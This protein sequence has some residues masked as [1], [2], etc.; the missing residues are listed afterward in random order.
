[1]H[2]F[3]KPTGLARA[4]TLALLSSTVAALPCTAMA[5]EWTVAEVQP[6]VQTPALTDQDADADADDPAIYVDAADTNKSFVVTAVKNGGIRVYDFGGQ[7]LQ[8]ILPVED[9]RINNVDIV[10]DFKMVDGSV[11]DLAIGADRG[12][13]VIRIYRI[14]ASGG[15]PLTEITAA[16]AARAFPRR[17]TSDGS[18]EEENPAEDQA[19]VY[20][21]TA[22]HDKAAEKVSVV[23]TQRHQPVVGIFSLEA[24]EGGTVA[25]VFDH[26]FQV[27]TSHSGQDLWQESEED[28]LADF[29]PQFE[30]VVVDRTTGT[31]YAGQEDVGIWSVPVSGGEPE[32]AYETR[33]SSSSSFFNPDSV[34]TRDVEGLSIYYAAS[35]TRYLLAS[36][37]GGAHGEPPVVSDAPYDDSFVVFDLGADELEPLGSFRVSAAENIDAVQESDGDD[38][39]SVALPGFPNGVFITQDGYAGDLNELDGETDSTN[40]KFVDWAEIAA[41]FE[42]PLEVTPTGWSPRQ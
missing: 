7:L 20:G 28:A 12:L 34:I 18:A 42:P 17:P 33:G 22:W 6:S 3:A 41:S 24:R 5:A 29:S 15:E 36:S 27:P 35:G 31:V 40:F 25:A 1:M 26:D 38:V 21:L 13:D 32:L 23:G 19:T 37:Q 16:D 4:A 30:G 11:A 10:Y 8:S 14:D 9:S 39:I 2:K